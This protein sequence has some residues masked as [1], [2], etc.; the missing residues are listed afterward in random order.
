M[1]AS[2]ELEKYARDYLEGRLEEAAQARL[3]AAIPQPRATGGSMFVVALRYIRFAL[4][5]L[6]GV[7]YL[8]ATD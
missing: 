6:L 4:T 7:A 3:R 2:Y 8:N 1:I 5:S